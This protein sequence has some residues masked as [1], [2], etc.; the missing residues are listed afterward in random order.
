MLTVF[1]FCRGEPGLVEVPSGKNS[2]DLEFDNTDD[3]KTSARFSAELLLERY[4]RP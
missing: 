4:G 1:N 3:F 2:A